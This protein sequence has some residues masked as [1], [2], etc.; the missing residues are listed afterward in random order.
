MSA[1]L[2]W[3]EWGGKAFLVFSSLILFFLFPSLEVVPFFATSAFE[4]LKSSFFKTQNS[5]F[6]LIN[7]DFIKISL[8]KCLLLSAILTFTDKTPQSVKPFE[9]GATGYVLV[10][11]KAVRNCIYIAYIKTF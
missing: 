8:F 11:T 9:N 5:H 1:Q 4:L 2:E 3:S 6:L 10:L 7:N